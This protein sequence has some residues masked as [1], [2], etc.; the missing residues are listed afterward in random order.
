MGIPLNVDWQQ[1]LLHLFNFVILA[2]GLWLLLYKPV[3]NFM[4]KRE[5]YYK[6]MD[7]AA[8]DRLASAEEE[9]SKYSGLIEKAQDEAAELKKKA[10]ADAETAAKAHIAEAEQEKQRILDDARRAA[11]AEKNKVLQEANA[12]IEE[13]VSAA[14]DKLL[15]P[16]G[17]A[18]DSFEDSGKE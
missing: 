5:A 6:D 1:I 10:M 13:M 7:K 18:Y 14:V 15:V 17:S 4:A 12:Q 9:Q 3:K 2:G 8:N 11:Q 16:A